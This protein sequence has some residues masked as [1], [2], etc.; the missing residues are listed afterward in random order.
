MEKIQT[1]KQVT[2]ITSVFFS[3]SLKYR[4][5]CKKHDGFLENQRPASLLSPI[6]SILAW[7]L[8]LIKC[9]SYSTTAPVFFWTRILPERT[10]S[11]LLYFMT[12]KFHIKVHW[13]VSF[14]FTNKK[15][16]LTK[17][18]PLLVKYWSTRGLASE[19]MMYGRER[20]G[21]QKKA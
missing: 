16:H 9:C 19:F 18:P 7:K 12:W 1:E 3:Y 15:T 2:L 20:K 14:G 13:N 8:N 17:L 4:G 6:I 5:W 21:P 10:H 11:N